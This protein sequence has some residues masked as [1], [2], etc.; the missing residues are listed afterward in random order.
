[1]SE[2]VNLRWM[3]RGFHAREFASVKTILAPMPM[4]LLLSLTKGLRSFTDN[5][6]HNFVNPSNLAGFLPCVRSC[7]QPKQL[8][9]LRRNCL[10][11]FE[12]LNITFFQFRP[13]VA[14]RFIYSSKDSKWLS[15]FYKLHLETRLDISRFR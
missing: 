4:V 9:Y 3:P 11:S 13:V 6:Q 12:Q 2:L 15:V 5:D 1:M 14:T 10:I 8:L 7:Y